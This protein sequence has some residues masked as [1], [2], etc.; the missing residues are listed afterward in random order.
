MENNCCELEE[1]LRYS[2]TDRTRFEKAA[3]LQKKLFKTL[4]K[5]KKLHKVQIFIKQRLKTT[6]PTKKPA[7]YA[8]LKST[9]IAR[10]RDELTLAANV[11]FY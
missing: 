7:H 11:S 9:P 3:I 6:V 8:W 1:F 4:K 10:V 2:F 5:K